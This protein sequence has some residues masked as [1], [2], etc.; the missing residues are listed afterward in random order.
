MKNAD[1]TC[2]LKSTIHVD[3]SRVGDVADFKEFYYEL[4]SITNTRY[5]QVWTKT[6]TEVKRP[7]WYA[8]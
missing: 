5:F 3:W 2:N 7:L 1:P 4:L 6:C 8:L